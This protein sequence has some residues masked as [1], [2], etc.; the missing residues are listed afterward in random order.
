MNTPRAIILSGYGLNCEE[1]TAHAFNLSGGHVDIVHINDLIDKPNLLKQYQIL[2]I[3]GGFSY[4]DDLGSGKAYANKL[5]NHL[6]KQ[7]LDFAEKDKLIIGI[8]NGFQ[9]LTNLGLL[10][11]VLTFN[12]NNRYTDSWVDVKITTHNSVI[13]RRSAA[14]D[15][16]ILTKK[17]KIASSDALLAMTNKLSPWLTGI[18]N[19]SLPIAHGEGKFVAGD[20]TMASIKKQKMIAGV[21]YKGAMCNYQNLTPN[22]NGSTL[23]IAMLTSAN[24]KI[25]GTM[26]HP[27]RAMFFTQAPNWP[28]LKEKLIRS[29]KSLPKYGQGLQIFKNAVNYFK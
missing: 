16:A 11:G 17:K 15:E 29:G 3:P 22:P 8:C 5:N 6:K 23:D 12:N 20:K 2:A 14:D 28:L 26:P 27:E 24:G 18:K 21:Y 4:G 9:I 1:E 19:L 25:L 13:A 10:P 7:L